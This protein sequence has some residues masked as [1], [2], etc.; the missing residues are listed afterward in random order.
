MENE[1][2]D[3]EIIETT[4]DTIDF[5]DNEESGVGILPIA[6][7][8]ALVGG[9]IAAAVKFGPKL[10]D[11]AMNKLGYEKTEKPEDPEVKDQY[12]EV[13]ETKKDTKKK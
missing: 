13:E 1:I 2:M 3:E 7:G 5:E 8:I 11:K 10:F 4:A 9:G 12:V 6:A